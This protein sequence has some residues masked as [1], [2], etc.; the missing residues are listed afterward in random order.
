MNGT[1][2]AD[3]YACASEP[4]GW[5]HVLDSM[6]RLTGAR[7]ATIQ[8]LCADGEQPYSRFILRDSLSESLSALHDAH[9]SDRVNPRVKCSHGPWIH[10][11]Q[12]IV[13]DQDLFEP[14][15]EQLDEIRRLTAAVGLGRFLGAGLPISS[16][17]F[18]VIA[19]HRPLD[20]GHDFSDEHKAIL[21]GFMPHLQQTICLAEKFC[22]LRKRAAYLEAAANKLRWGMIVCDASAR[23]IW[24]N[25]ATETLLS[26]VAR[27]RISAGLLAAASPRQTQ[28]LRRAIAFAARIGNEGA[29]PD[30]ATAFPVVLH[31]QS[32][33][34]APLHLM[35]LPLEQ[36][37][38]DDPAIAQASGEPGRVLL[39]TSDHS[40]SKML[41]SDLVARLFSLTATEAGLAVELCRGRTLT[42]Y[43]AS[44]HVSIGTARFQL[45]RI[46]A[47]TQTARQ[48]D[49]VRAVCCSIANQVSDSGTQP[50]D[51]HTLHSLSRH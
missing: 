51:R 32:G 23:V 40:V 31:S 18:I 29:E 10:T 12:M 41:R 9:L 33:T 38:I 43:A 28:E 6:C 50:R 1:L 2:L 17:Q 46:L 14:G 49:L 4:C 44:R 36:D 24:H 45:K 8:L 7:A 42:E 37:A 5:P 19:L 34:D 20:D 25:R 48:S 15:S 11:R 16:G 47:K 21:T 22:T 35:A 3:L 13:R 27:L 39:L 30:T 26:E